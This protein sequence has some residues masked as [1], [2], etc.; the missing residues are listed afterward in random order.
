MG[1][2][3]EIAADKE[4]SLQSAYAEYLEAFADYQ[5]YMDAHPPAH[6]R[7]AEAKELSRLESLSGWKKVLWEMEKSRRYKV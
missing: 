5:S 1:R 3:S 6:R 4:E 2:M 7:E